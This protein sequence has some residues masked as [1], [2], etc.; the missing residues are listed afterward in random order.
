MVILTQLDEKTRDIRYSRAIKEHS[1]IWIWWSY[2]EEDR[3]A[4]YCEWNLAKSRSSTLGSFAMDMELSYMRVKDRNSNAE[5]H[6][7]F[8]EEVITNKKNK[9]DKEKEQDFNELTMST[10]DF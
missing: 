4:G 10:E 2:G 1:N 9:G 5:S 3:E 7:D 8:D 6:N